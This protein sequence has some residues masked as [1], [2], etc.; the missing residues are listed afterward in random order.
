[1]DPSKL[2]HLRQVE[3]AKPCSE[4]WESMEGN[5][6][7]RFCAGCGCFV[8]NIAAMEAISAEQ[9]LSGAE[10]VCTRIIVDAKKGVLTRD[11]W[12]PRLAIVGAVASSVAGCHDSTASLT[13]TPAITAPV[14][15][16]PL[17][18]HTDAEHASL[19][20]TQDE[21]SQCPELGWPNIVAERPTQKFQQKSKNKHEATKLANGKSLLSKVSK[22]PAKHKP[23]KGHQYETKNGIHVLLGDVMIPGDQPS[24][25]EAFYEISL[26][27]KRKS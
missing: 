24:K 6:I 14:S 9:L 12:I 17:G 2:N 1:M 18:R 8:H 22:K 27:N 21:S 16:S 5:D 4:D 19:N 7:E 11:G 26:S 13:G 15:N 3:I 10:K 20:L 23:V 25:D